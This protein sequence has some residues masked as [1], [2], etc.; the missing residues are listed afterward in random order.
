MAAS[1]RRR[2]EAA[3]PQPQPILR[4]QLVWL[5]PAE[6][7]DIDRFVDWLNDAE[8]AA[9]LAL[10]SPLSHALEERWF[11]S[12]VER[13]GRELY[14]F[15]ICRLDDGQP[16]GT[17]GLEEIDHLN[18]SAAFGIA[19]GDKA[20]WGQ[21]YGPDAV[22]TLCDFGFGELR[23]ERIWLDVYADNARAKRA[24]E[25]VG[26]LHEGRLRHAHFTRGRHEDVDR[27][28]LLRD[29]WLAQRQD[30]SAGERAT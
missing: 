24:Y 27:M 8:T 15:V 21:G 6:R 29:D 10:R 14:H 30:D 23:L 28:A 7:D 17:I 3:G 2:E 16:I 5:R 18:G 25:K 26:F 12:M 1:E 9:H 13:H 11:E 19:I 4:G 20:M 22:A